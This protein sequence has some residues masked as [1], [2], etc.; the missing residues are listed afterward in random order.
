M[1]HRDHRRIDRLVLGEERPFV[2]RFADAP[3]PVLG[4]RHRVVGHD[5]ATGIS[6]V[7]L[8]GDPRDFVS[9]LLHVA[10]DAAESR[11]LMRKRRRRGKKR[12][13]W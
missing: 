9:H 3:Y 5:V 2:H 8:T 6:I 10:A 4:R 13:R 11:R 12:R 7:A 1:R